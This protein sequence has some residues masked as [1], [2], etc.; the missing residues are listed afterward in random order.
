[1]ATGRSWQP[2]YIA[3]RLSRRKFLA[4]AA[5]GAG[6]AALI[7]C[8]GGESG[9]AGTQVITVDPSGVRK[10]GNVV[11]EKDNWKL[12]DEP[13]ALDG[14]T[15]RIRNDL[16][17]TVSYDWYL[18][19]TGV[20]EEFN[21]R[22]YE[23]LTR[24]NVNPTFGPISVPGVDPGSIEGLK[25]VPGLAES[26]EVSNDGLT[27]T[28]TM[29]K[30]VKFHNVPPV[31]GREMTINDWR[32]TAEKYLEIGFNR[33]AIKNI[34]D[35]FE[36]PDQ[37]HWVWKLKEPYAFLIHNMN[38]KDFAIKIGPKEL[39]DN[40][41]LR[42]NTQIGTGP[43]VVERVQP[44]IDWMFRRHEQYWAGKPH[45]DKWHYPLIPEIANAYAQFVAKNVIRHNPSSRDVLKIRGD[46]PEALLSANQL[47]WYGISRGIFG[48]YEKDTAPWKDAR[49]RIAIN[50]VVDQEQI[51]R[52]RSNAD[53]FRQA[54]V[55]VEIGPMTHS[56]RDPSYWL[57]PWKG[58]L[59]ADS[60]NYKY[61]LAGAK[62]LTTAAGFPNGADIPMYFLLGSRN[63]EQKLPLDFYNKA[64]GIINVEEHW[65]EMQPFYDQV[66]QTGNFKGFQPYTPAQSSFGQAQFDK[67]LRENYH[68]TGKAPTYP[69]PELDAMI[70]KQLVENDANARGS[71]YKDIQR[72]LAKN[73]N[74]VPAA[75]PFGGF[76]FQWLWVH[77]VPQAIEKHWL[78]A[79]TPNRNG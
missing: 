73:F 35:R 12:A 77:N 25:P 26:W 56:S 6:A 7:A 31:N 52:F 29:R 78:D 54:G 42:S 45:I 72:Y 39:V 14:G 55:E 74:G 65:L 13:Q 61:D 43:M 30:G 59:G 36:W 47:S 22:S 50:K 40:D 5:A 15:L 66:Q 20:V 71:I 68:S 41:Q 34:L 53:A 32:A 10:P 48:R 69:T 17:L 9:D 19:N 23:Y 70:K 1:M 21:D 8:G 18:A 62:Q 24:G 2:N 75:W 58:E 76:S 16:D 27:W 44:S 63:D 60:E 57:D 33:S 79:S 46:V 28:F 11:Y 67:I 51:A 64:T 38:N 3:N 49:V 4:G 37:T